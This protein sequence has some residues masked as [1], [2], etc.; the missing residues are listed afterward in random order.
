[1]AHAAMPARPKPT[2][3]RIGAGT[4][5]AAQ[6]TSPARPHEEPTGAVPT[7][8]KVLREPQRVCQPLTFVRRPYQ[9]PAA[10][11]MWPWQSGVHGALFVYNL[12]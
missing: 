10:C 3:R 1:M 5:A 7:T 9:S 2:G 12:A 4:C 8:V 6:E 11:I